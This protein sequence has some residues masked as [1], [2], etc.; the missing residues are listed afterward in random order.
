VE[1]SKKLV[2]VSWG[3]AIGLTILAVILPCYQ[4]SVEGVIASL[5]YSWGE[6]TGVQGF[7]LWKA[8]NEN[9]HKYAMKYMDKI[10]S[11]FDPDIAIR[12]AEIVLKD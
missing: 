9:R 5:P 11:K 2:R 4:V 6:V 8:K 3:V 1:F 7:Y 12:I 10:A